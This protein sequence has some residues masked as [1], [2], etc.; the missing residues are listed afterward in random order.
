MTVGVA[1]SAGGP[2]APGIGTPKVGTGAEGALTS[3]GAG[4]G[5]GMDAGVGARQF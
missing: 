4:V 1:V 2:V 3:T 5:K